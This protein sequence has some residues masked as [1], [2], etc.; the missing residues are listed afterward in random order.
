MQKI[1]YEYYFYKFVVTLYVSILFLLLPLEHK[2]IFGS[3]IIILWLGTIF[4]TNKNSLLW[5]HNDLVNN[6][7]IFWVLIFFT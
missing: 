2:I 7:I 3:K 1:F 6:F 4:I 5:T